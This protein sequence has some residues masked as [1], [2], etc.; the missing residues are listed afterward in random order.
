M[1]ACRTC[2][3]ISTETRLQITDAFSSN[4]TQTANEIKPQRQLKEDIKILR[5]FIRELHLSGLL[6]SN[7]QTTWTTH[8]QEMRPP[9][10]GTPWDGTGQKQVTIDILIIRLEM[11][12]SL[13]TTYVHVLH[14]LEL[15]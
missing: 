2:L 8:L 15:D 1:R 3:H 11:F 5:V 9:G 14:M 12:L 13:H 4:N 10:K 6:L 7:G